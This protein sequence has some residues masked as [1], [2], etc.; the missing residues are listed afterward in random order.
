VAIALAAVLLAPRSTPTPTPS[1]ST[2]PSQSTVPVAQPRLS[3]P[4]LVTFPQTAQGAA[5][6]ES[7][8]VT[9]DG[10]ADLTI[11]DLRQLSGTKDFVINAG[12]CRGLTLLPT[13]SCEF[14]VIFTPT[15][16]GE[17]RGDLSIVMIELPPTSIGL[18]GMGTTPP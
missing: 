11:V 8:T 2:S 15:T 13:H 3:A 10:V 5:A 1:A 17:R 9:N 4:S 18:T 12:G 6:R 16:T 14:E 7:V